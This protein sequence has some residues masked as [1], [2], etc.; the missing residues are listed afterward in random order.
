[1]LKYI[2]TFRLRTLPLS[3]AG[4]ILGAGYAYPTLRWDVFALA[5][6]TTLSL[7][8]LANLCNEVGD[9][10]HGT[11]DGQQGRVAYGLQSGAITLR[12]MWVC[13][14]VFIGLCI[15]FGTALVWRSFG[16]LLCVESL[17][18]LL[19]GGLAIVG[20]MTYTMGKHAY[21]YHGFGDL[22]VMIFFGLLSGV[23][24][25]YLQTHSLNMEIFEAAFAVGM[26]I[27]GV[28]N[29]NNIRDMENDVAHGKITLAAR[30]GK[31]QAKVYHACLLVCS[32][33]SFMGLGHYWV[34]LVAPVWYWHL[35]DVFN[36]DG[37]EL[38]LQMPVLMFSTLVLAFLA[39]L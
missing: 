4:I 37:A 5:I 14:Y 26:P 15:V 31:R 16:T 38:D 29:L 36:K 24:S 6:M 11:D 20:A 23:G 10:Q 30:L 9:A 19:L 12:E 34:L 18:F 32:I 25:Y 35:K 13:I 8:I 22:G 33:V 21:G 2:Q 28:I 39:C 7:Q 27:V 17:V 3:M 1:M